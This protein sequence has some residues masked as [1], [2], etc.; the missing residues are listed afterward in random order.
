[1]YANLAALNQLRA[2]R[3]MNCFEFRPH[4]GEAGD[5]DHLTSCFLTASKVRNTA[6]A[7][8]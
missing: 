3:G 5:V 1:M 7:P 8:P 6:A 2:A 4:S